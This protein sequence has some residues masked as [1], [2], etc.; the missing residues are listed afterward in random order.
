M[1]RGRPR[2]WR[3]RRGPAAPGGPPGVGAP[4]DGVHLPGQG[5]ARPRVL[6]R[7]G[8]DVGGSGAPSRGAPRGQLAGVNGAGPETGPAPCS[9]WRGQFPPAPL[10]RRGSSRAAGRPRRRRLPALPPGVP[11]LGPR[12]PAER[13]K[14]LVAL[15]R[16]RN[17]LEAELAQVKSAAQP[18]QDGLQRLVDSVLE[19]L[20]HVGRIL[21]AGEPEERRPPR[22]ATPARRPQLTA[23]CGGERAGL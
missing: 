15:E 14:A 8:R 20:Y 18:G 17:R 13:V 1:G 19:T 12:V 16:E 11:G 21:D 9:R 22:Q 7:P 4:G 5:V 3:P 6:R 10:P 23:S 2:P